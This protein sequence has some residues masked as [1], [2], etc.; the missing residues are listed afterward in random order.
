LTVIYMLFVLGQTLNADAN[1]H[2]GLFVRSIR[3]E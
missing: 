1:A 2:A 3:E